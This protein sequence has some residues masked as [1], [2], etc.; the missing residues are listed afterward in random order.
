MSADVARFYRE[1]SLKLC[2]LVHQKIRH[3]HFTNI[4]LIA[5]TRR[6]EKRMQTLCRS[7]FNRAMATPKAPEK[8]IIG[9]IGA[10]GNTRL[11]HIPELLTIENHSI[12]IK[13]IA[14]RTEQSALEVAK[15]FNVPHASG[16]WQDVINDPEINAVVIGTWP[17]MHKQLVIAAL[18]AGKHVL[19]E[20]R[21]VRLGGQV[22]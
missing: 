13:T 16:N 8:I 17:Y 4:N 20:A 3:L 12:E 6:T 11:R 19:C 2:R 10:G 5:K 9:V 7:S 22:S 18:E 14:N 15:I 1:P 21:M